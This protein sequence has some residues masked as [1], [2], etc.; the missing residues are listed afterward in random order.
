MNTT[1][2]HSKVNVT[3]EFSDPLY[4]AGHEVTG[5]M[6]VECK[7]DKGLGLSMVMI[8]LFAMQGA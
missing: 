7:A 2:H 5:K 4:V 8:E 3:L 6:D 1:T